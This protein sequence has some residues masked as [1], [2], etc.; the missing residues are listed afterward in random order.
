MKL[1]H[2][3]LAVGILGLSQWA[4]G[5]S[6]SGFQIVQ[7]GVTYQCN[8]VSGSGSPGAGTVDC[9]D[10]AYQGP[11]SRS[12]SQEI[13]Q[14][15]WSTA[16]AECAIRAYA[17]PFSRQESIDL[18]KGAV[19]LTDGPDACAKKA[20][21]GPFS[22]EQALKI[23]QGGTVANADCAIKAYAGPYTKDEAVKM[24]SRP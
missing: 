22:R 24:C 20:Y 19:V 9:V 7:S 12:E 3:V 14:G 6:S 11:F 1:H 18:C 10:R 8:P 16:P 4:V 2:W 23:C 17:G 15:A 5:Q 21:A 13:C